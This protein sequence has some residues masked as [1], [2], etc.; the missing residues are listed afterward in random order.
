MSTDCPLIILFQ[1]DTSSPLPAW[2]GFNQKVSSS[3][4][5]PVSKIGYLPVID[6]SPTEM[7]T[8]NLVLTRS[9]DIANIL[10][11]PNIVLVMDQAIYSKAQ[12]IRWQN[13]EFTNRLVIRL[14]EFHIA[15]S[16]LP[17]IGKRFQ[18]AG[19]EDV[20]IES[21]I[22]AQGSVNGVMSGHRYNRSVRCHK[23]VAEAMHRLKDL[24]LQYEIHVER[25]NQNNDNY[26]FWS[27]YLEMVQLLLMFLRATREGNW[28]LH[29]S[30]VRDMLPWYF[31]YGRVNYSRYLPVYLQEMSTLQQTHP[32]VYEKFC[33]GEF[34]V[35]R[36]N[37]HAF[38]KTACDQVIEQT[39]NR[40]SKTKG[41]L[42]GFTQNKGALSRWIL[43]HPSRTAIT[44][45][46][47]SQAGKTDTD[48]THKDH[49]T[50]R[51]SRD[52]SD[53]Q[54]VVSTL[55]SIGSPF[56]SESD[57]QL[58]HLTA[59]TVAIDDIKSDLLHAY[60]KGEEAYQ[61][62]QKERLAEG[63]KDF[64]SKDDSLER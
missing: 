27:S 8:V 49:T 39:F 31:A 43:S 63:S 22:L 56:T 26:S 57:D 2:T 24:Q 37:D 36:S 64:F 1:V 54:E 18:D 50:L 53:V 48:S 58:A 11:L 7:S 25:C 35:Q 13:E 23:I 15:M 34:A 60:S 61:H 45:T 38:A 59:G 16:F 14:G 29:L 62:F 20:M 3:K 44:N 30:T 32:N 21:G 51:I 46:C 40:E 10:L 4:I 55:M 5:L 52:E 42:V 33:S 12:Q 9:I 17:T 6:A 41:G 19:L 28:Q 47:F